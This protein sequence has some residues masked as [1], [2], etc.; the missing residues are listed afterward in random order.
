MDSNRD[1]KLLAED[2]IKRRLIK[3]MKQFNSKIIDQIKTVIRNTLLVTK[4]Q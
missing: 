4:R 3:N 2:L 1:Y